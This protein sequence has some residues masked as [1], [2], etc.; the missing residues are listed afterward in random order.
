MPN[1]EVGSGAL[2]EP[3]EIATTRVLVATCGY[4]GFVA[5][6]MVG[7][8]FY[9]RADAPAALSPPDERR[10]PA[11]S[12]QISPEHDLSRFLQEQQRDLDHYTWFDRSKGIATI[13]IDEAIKIVAARKDHGYDPPEQP[14]SSASDASKGVQ[15]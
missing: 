6:A 4:L 10:F 15:Q 3:P 1:D 13:P 2:F 12:L 8:F 7:M 5:V 9:V 14:A 11:P